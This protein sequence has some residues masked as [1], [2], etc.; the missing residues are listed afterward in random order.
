[1]NGD[2][3]KFL[4]EVRELS[5]LEQISSILYWDQQTYMPQGA[6]QIRGQQSALLAGIY[7][8]RLTSDHMGRLI[9]SLKKQKLSVDGEVILREVERKWKKESSIPGPLV[10][11]IT[12]TQAIGYEA[13]MKA[14]K[15]SDFKKFEPLLDRMIGLKMR[16]A[17]YI[18]YEDKPYDALL[19]DYEPGVGA[20]D[21]ESLFKRLIAKLVPVSKKILAEP[22]P[23]NAIP[24]G[25]YTLED[26]LKFVSAISTGMGF[27]TNCGRI[28]LSAHPFTGGTA[29]DVRITFRY[30]EDNP[31]YAIFP[32]IHETGHALY[33]QGFKQ[34]YTG[35]PLAEGVSMAFHESQSRLWE[36]VVG[37][38]LPFWTCLYPKM[39]Q[40]FPE[41][42]K[43]PVEA[44]H[45]EINR[46]TPSYIRVDADE[47]TY[48]LH[49]AVRFEA[50]AA[51]FDGRLKTSEIPEFWNEHFKK[52]LGLEITDNALGCLQDVHWSGG[53][54]GYFPSYTLGNLYAAQLW[55]TV[56]KQLPDIEDEIAAGNTG[57]L[58]GWLRENV[59]R[60]GK[61]YSSADLMKKVTGSPISEDFFVRYVKEKYGS[62]YGISL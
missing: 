19:D 34:K 55:D 45:K 10:R 32:I 39:Q 31:Y 44:W 37:R 28:D 59:H 40:A 47:L 35:T 25:R 33:E 49:I 46:V 41:F 21:I 29:Q 6:F 42:K 43:V 3:R 17:E 18:G 1:M 50:E 4:Q 61:R 24:A 62:V 48:N 20:A 8:D 13:W 23:E 11:E 56:R 15:A 14:R 52:Y 2:Y 38:G 51:I 12:K 36:N 53:G 5:T 57:M 22:L 30:Q 16:A 27:D 26:Q 60:H 54:F 9:R 58:L 7:H